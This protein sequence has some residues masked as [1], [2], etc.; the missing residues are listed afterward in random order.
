LLDLKDFKVK[1]LEEFCRFVL[2][3]FEE[4]ENNLFGK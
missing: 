3:I 1:Y 2:L 4:I